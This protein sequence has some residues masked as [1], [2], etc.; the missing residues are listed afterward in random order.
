MLLTVL[1]E[2]VLPGEC[3]VWT[4]TLV[5]ALGLLGFADGNARQ[6]IARMGEDGLIT[7]VKHGR[8][9]RWHLSPE[10]ERLL[11]NG[12]QRIYGLGRRRA[13]WNHRWLVVVCSIPET[14]RE[15]RRRLQTQLQF[16]G[17]GFLAP[18][19]AVSPHVSAESTASDVLRR[20]ELT[21]TAMVFRAETGELTADGDL[22]RRSWDLDELA[23]TY[24]EFT[25]T[26]APV[27]PD[28]DAG[29]FTHVVRLVHAW[30]RFPFADPDLPTELLPADW[31]GAAARILFDDA[32]GAW[33]P[34]AIAHYERL[35]EAHG[36]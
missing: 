5:D 33:R 4:G 15:K 29:A 27:R 17:F 6:A 12:A 19:I 34:P 26:F 9:T 30:R 7:A 14:Q 11:D 3:A 31:A 23:R 21:D 36:G 35:E 24:E 20:L 10:G 13:E 25:A 18:S 16:A 1:G 32:R 2:F 28:G 22:V 8:R